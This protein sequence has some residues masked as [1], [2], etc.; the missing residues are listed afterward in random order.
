[1]D[2]ILSKLGELAKDKEAWR[3][4]VHGIAKS[5]TRLSNWNELKT[6]DKLTHSFYIVLLKSV[7]LVLIV[8]DTAIVAAPTYILTN[9]AGGFPFLHILNNTCNACYFLSFWW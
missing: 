9:S 3:A 4:A 7:V 8:R 6:Q 2:M 5:Q 1:M